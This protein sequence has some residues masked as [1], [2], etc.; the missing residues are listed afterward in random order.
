GADAYMLTHVI[1]NWNDEL[2]AKI[3][4][5]VRGAMRDDSI[6][7]LGEQVIATGN[8][9]DFAKLLDLEML[10]LTDG[11]RERTADDFERLLAA[12][13]LELRRVV[14]TASGAKILEAGLPR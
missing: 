12:A 3:L 10:V 5:N 4:T 13:G 6:V 9:P 14:N 2:A 1:H 8:A 7:L 11:G